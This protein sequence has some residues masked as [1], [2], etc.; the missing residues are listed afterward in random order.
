[1]SVPFNCPRL[2]MFLNRLANRLQTILAQGA[3]PTPAE[4]AEVLGVTRRTV[5]RYWLFARTWLYREL[6]SR[7]G[8]SESDSDGDLGTRS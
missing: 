7:L 8:S 3:E 2:Q 5:D 1:M 4:I 6:R